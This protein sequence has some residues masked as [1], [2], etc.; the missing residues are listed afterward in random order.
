MAADFE[1]AFFAGGVFL[2]GSFLGGERDP[3]FFALEASALP[4]GAQI[5]AA[6]AGCFLDAGAGGESFLT[7]FLL[8][9]LIP[10]SPSAEA[11]FAA[12]PCVCLRVLFATAG[13]LR[14]VEFDL[15]GSK[16]SSVSFLRRL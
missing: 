10:S 16:L 3:R 2:E 5:A 4:F 7:D 12:F 13:S 6:L 15:T 14:A 9:D 11:L 8:L 1:A